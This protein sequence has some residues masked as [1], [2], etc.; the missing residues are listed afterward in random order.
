MNTITALIV[1]FVLAV[2]LAGIGELYG[3]EAYDGSNLLTY[4]AKIEFERRWLQPIYRI[5][6]GLVIIALWV[7]VIL[8]FK[9]IFFG[10][11]WLWMVLILPA[12]A[13]VMVVAAVIVTMLI[14]CFMLAIVACIWH[15][16]I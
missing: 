15:W 14:L 7:D 3:K 13:V 9:D 2:L 12:S 5:C 16:D 11:E 10:I 6:W 4:P 1:I 8:M